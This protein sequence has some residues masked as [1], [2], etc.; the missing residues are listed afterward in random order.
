MQCV[1]K[2]QTSFAQRT[3][4]DQ[5]RNEGVKV[6]KFTGESSTGIVENANSGY[7]FANVLALGLGDA[8]GEKGLLLQVVLTLF[9]GHQ[10]TRNVADRR[11][12]WSFNMS[13]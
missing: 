2:L 3:I 4:G 5:K 6:G 9:H 13:H 10:I 7:V 8:A 1:Q 11:L 12:G